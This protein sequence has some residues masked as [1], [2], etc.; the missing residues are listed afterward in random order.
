MANPTFTYQSDFARKY[1]SEGRVEGKAECVVSAL[2]HRGLNVSGEVAS[3]IS[4]CTDPDL[5]DTW[6]E[7][8][9][10]VDTAEDIFD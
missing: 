10:G 7:R 1:I 6:M 5:L 2:R 3:R 8:A 9:L 4:A